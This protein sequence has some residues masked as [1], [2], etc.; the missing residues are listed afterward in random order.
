MQPKVV[1]DLIKIEGMEMGVGE[2]FT[3]VEE[4]NG[5]GCWSRW[6]VSRKCL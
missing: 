2:G 3:E 1:S 5:S 4:P 6:A